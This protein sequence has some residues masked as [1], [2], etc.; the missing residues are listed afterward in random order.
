MSDPKKNVSVNYVLLSIVIFLNLC[1][2]N[3]Q[4]SVSRNTDSKPWEWYRVKL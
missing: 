4:G 3:K 2:K 1:L